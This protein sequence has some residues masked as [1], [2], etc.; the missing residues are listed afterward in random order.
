MQFAGDPFQVKLCQR[1]TPACGRQ[2][3]DIQ[4]LAVI[5][6]L[7]RL[8][9]WRVLENRTA[10]DRP[11]AM[12]RDASIHHHVGAEQ[13]LDAKV[14]VEVTRAA[15]PFREFAR[16]VSN[17]FFSRPFCRFL[18]EIG[19]RLDVEN[20]TYDRQRKMVEP[21]RLIG[22]QRLQKDLSNSEIGPMA[23]SG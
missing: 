19:E 2:L 14:N 11:T 22:A 12:P 20:R 18:R 6:P 10:L 16:D 5:P 13:V 4:E 9:F 3:L 8:F 15:A 7:E 1:F 23:F 21:D 17:D